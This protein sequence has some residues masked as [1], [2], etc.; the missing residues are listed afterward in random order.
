MS[1]LSD[2]SLTDNNQISSNLSLGIAQNQPKKS[3]DDQA[4]EQSEAHDIEI[5]LSSEK[6]HLVLHLDVKSPHPTLYVII[7]SLRSVRKVSPP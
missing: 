7:F 2:N 1:A 3:P 5:S 4:E 6:F